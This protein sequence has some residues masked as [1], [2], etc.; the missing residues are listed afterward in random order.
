M[1]L[2]SACP[3]LFDGATNGVLD[4]SGIDE[5]WTSTCSAGLGSD[6]RGE[7]SL[8]VMPGRVCWL[9]GGLVRKQYTTTAPVLKVKYDGLECNG[10]RG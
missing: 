2:A 5:G 4:V 7:E 3:V 1:V 10:N 6:G 8:V 9:A